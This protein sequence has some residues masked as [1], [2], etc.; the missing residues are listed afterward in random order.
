MRQHGDQNRKLKQGRE[1]RPTLR[2]L[3][4]E[5]YEFLHHSKKIHLRGLHHFNSKPLRHLIFFDM[6]RTKI[7]L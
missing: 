3:Q 6:T 5:D 7:K 2:T 4:T 1:Y